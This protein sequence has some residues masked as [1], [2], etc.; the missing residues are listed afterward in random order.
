MTNQQFAAAITQFATDLDN[1]I[2][3]ED[4]RDAVEYLA[5]KIGSES[6]NKIAD[7]FGLK[8]SYYKA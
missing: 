3:M 5:N 8:S 7:V 6:A 2:C 4:R 1:S